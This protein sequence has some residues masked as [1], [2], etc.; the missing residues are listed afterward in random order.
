M[1]QSPAPNAETNEFNHS[2]MEVIP[3]TGR[4]IVPLSNKWQDDGG[5]TLV[6]G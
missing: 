6:V 2:L 4:T 3:G 5:I 1:L